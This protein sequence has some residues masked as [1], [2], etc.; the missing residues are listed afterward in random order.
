MGQRVL[1]C[2]DDVVLLNVINTVLLA[3][4]FQVDVASSLTEAKNLLK[5]K[6]YDGIVIDFNLGRNQYG[7]QIHEVTDLPVMIITGQEK[8]KMLQNEIMMQKPFEF[9]AFIE[10]VKAL[11]LPPPTNSN[12]AQ[13]V[14]YYKIA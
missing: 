10:A 13:R 7:T 5:F 8:N 9:A 6:Q 1:L 2:D 14:K 11:C 4:G 3:N 12:V